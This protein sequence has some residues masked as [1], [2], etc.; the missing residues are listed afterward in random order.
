[1]RV[2]RWASLGLLTYRQGIVLTLCCLRLTYVP[3]LAVSDAM[4]RLIF[5]LDG[6]M[7]RNAGVWDV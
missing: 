1:M 3:L 2:L 4:Y 5:G 7:R 6:C